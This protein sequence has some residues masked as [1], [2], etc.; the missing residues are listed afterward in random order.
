MVNYN[1]MEQEDVIPDVNVDQNK[2]TQKIDFSSFDN[3]VKNNSQ[4]IDFSSFDNVVKKKGGGVVSS[5]TESP[6]P[7]QKQLP[8]FLK[9]GQEEAETGFKKPSLGGVVA[10]NEIYTMPMGI[11]PI[12]KTSSNPQTEPSFLSSAAKNTVA[13]AQNL[14]EKTVEKAADIDASALEF[15]RNLSGKIPFANKP[16]KIYENGEL[17]EYGKNIPYSDFLGKAIKGINEVKSQEQQLQQTTGKL[18]ETLGGEIAGGITSI[19]PDLA[20]A[21]MTGGKNLF[22]GT[23]NLAAIG[24]AVTSAFVREQAIAGA[25]KGYGE[26][27]KK[28][29]G[30]R[31]TLAT[32]LKESGKSAGQGALYELAGLGGSRLGNVLSKGLEN[33]TAKEAVNLA[34][35][36]A[37]FSLGVPTVE[38]AISEGKLPE[39]KDILKNFGIAGAMEAFHLAPAIV[40]KINNL[41]TGSAVNNFMNAPADVIDDL[42]Q[43]KQDAQNLNLTAMDAVKRAEGME[44]GAEKSQLLKTASNLTQAAD[45]KHVTDV[46]ANST[47]GL[48]HIAKDLPEDVRDAFMQKAQDIHQTLNPFELQKQNHAAN[49]SQAEEIAKQVEPLAKPENPNVLERIQAERKLNEAKGII[50]ENT[51]NLNKVLDEQ[52]KRNQQIQEAKLAEEGSKKYVVDGKEV[53]QEEFEA[54]Q[55]KPVGTKEIITQEVK[56]TEEFK[57]VKLTDLPDRAFAVGMTVE[58]FEDLKSKI[59]K[60][61]FTQPIIIDKES[62][63]VLDGQNRLLVAKDLGIK[64]VPSIYMD[65]PTRA[66]LNEKIKELEKQYIPTEEVKPIKVKEEPTKEQPIEAKLEVEEPIEEKQNK[67]EVGSSHE[68]LMNMAKRLGLKEPETGHTFKPEE[69]KERGQMLLKSGATVDD[70]N[71]KDFELYDRISI[72]E[73]HLYE[74]NKEADKIA[75]SEK[76]G[77]ESQKYKDKLDEIEKYSA[78]LKQLGT[79]AGHAFTSLQGSRDLDTGS[80]T[81]VVKKL[82]AVKNGVE[83]TEKEKE[84]I[85]KLTSENEELKKRAEEAESKAIEA[86]KQD[87]SEKEEPKEKDKTYKEKAKKAADTFRKLKTKPFTF[88]DENGNDIDIQKAGISWN[89]LVELGAKAIEKTGEIADGVKAIL[90]EI[91]DKEWYK[92]LSDK[93]KNKFEKDLTSHYSDTIEETPEAKKIRLLQKELENIQKGIIKQKGIKIEDTPAI[94]DLKD[95]I[96]EAKKNLGLFRGKEVP[97][98]K[99]KISEEQKRINRLEKELTDLEQGII[100]EQSEKFDD[101]PKIK[102]LKDKIYEQKQKLGLIPSKGKILDYSYGLTETLES[103]N[104]KRLEKQLEDLKQGIIKEPSEKRELSKAEKDLQDQIYEQK[105][106]MGLI[107]SK[108]EVEETSDYGLKITAEEK[109]IEKLQKEKDDLEKGIVKQKNVSNLKPTPEQQQRI[110]KLNDEI[111]DLKQNLGVL[112]SKVEKPLSEEEQ[113]QKDDEELNILQEKYVDKKDNVFTRDE[114]KEI[115]DYANK[116]YIENGIGYKEAIAKAAEDLGLTWEQV[117]NA[118]VTP[119]TKGISDEVFLKRNE[120][121]KNKNAIEKWIEDKGK[122][123]LVK[124]YKKIVGFPKA[125]MTFGHGHVFVGTHAIQNLTDPSHFAKTIEGFI[126]SY[127]FSYGND[128]NYQRKIEAL[129]NDINYAKANTAGLK[130]DP[131]HVSFDEE[132]SYQK[133]LGKFGNAGERGFNAVKVMRQQMF[134]Y[135]YNNLSESEKLDKKSLEQLA[136]HINAWTGTTNLKTPSWVKDAT[137]SS[138]LEGSR[139]ER[140]GAPFKAGYYALKGMTKYGTADEKVFA[141]VWAKRAGRTLGTYMTLLAANAAI[142]SVVNPDKKVNLTNPTKPDFLLPKFGDVEITID[143][144]AG[145]LSTI[146]F[147]SILYHYMTVDERKLPNNKS[148]GQAMYEQVG[149]YAQ[150]KLAP[151]WSLVKDAITRR[152]YSGNV[153]PYSS[154]Q[155]TGNKRKL[156]Y[157]EYGISHFAPLPIAEGYRVFKTSAEENGV[158]SAQLDNI[159]KGLKVGSISALTGAKIKELRNEPEE[160][161]PVE[162]IR[163]FKLKGAEKGRPATEAE[164]QDFEKVKNNIYQDLK[165]KT[166]KSGFGVQDEVTNKTIK[167]A[168]IKGTKDDDGN[169]LPLA[170]KAEKY[171]EINRLREIDSDLAKEAKF[172]HKRKT[173]IEIINEYKLINLLLLPYYIK[174]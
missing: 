31:E 130:N 71:N 110:D 155:P 11:E 112:K 167:K 21:A 20:L 136:K 3:V 144:S 91:K 19:V 142:Q 162:K 150:G 25:A 99:F 64:D 53:S 5:P 127:K 16:E 119:K 147:L 165:E 164:I 55:G 1:N 34:A 122:S 115:W 145:L 129:K 92:T 52:E 95:Q 108:G 170:T 83:I 123:K 116:T 17:T 66:D 43:S 140:I 61:G 41:R 148:R 88:K 65:N 105:Q 109:K 45:I 106:K 84:V 114:A 124:Y 102:E 38:S 39:Y 46:I 103:K 96:F 29:V 126:N 79:L 156:E 133:F 13:F 111:H 22:G 80:F 57:S 173:P 135:E 134:N 78:K 153:V 146:G 77:I 51:K 76:D 27:E 48:A 168:F 7:S 171:K 131:D 141:K 32:T 154:E 6:L 98:R 157:R 120:Y 121:N 73:A 23:S 93:D 151:F 28:G 42:V 82:R 4:K 2:P 117:A 137:F 94:K 10:G 54:M 101:T 107:P 15:L 69:Y 104:L 86:H 138:S 90:D 26:A 118:I 12:G 14:R 56:P 75:A 60:E 163:N 139:W 62:G 72:G 160:A 40:R 89:D 125:A 159:V 35:R 161:E 70:I 113:K 47:D 36:L 8:N 143:L 59:Q 18:P 100:K 58:K 49:I 128:V 132:Q 152:D 30:A 9:Y 149:K 37:T 97:E 174:N 63:N 44:D 68:A 74:M 172:V 24:N 169:D 81:S 67:R 50:D 87:F 33:V 166:E 85:K 158:T